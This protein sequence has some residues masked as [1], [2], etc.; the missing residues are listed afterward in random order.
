[1]AMDTLVLAANPGSASRKYSLYDGD[2]LLASLYFEYENGQIVC[3]A[4]SDAGSKRLQLGINDLEQTPEY[5]VK[6]FES[7]GVKVEHGFKCI[8]LRLVAPTSQF[9][10]DCLLDDTVISKLAE[11]EHLVPLHIRASL[12][13]ARGL[14]ACFADTPIVAISDSAFHIT[15]PDYA[16]N[17]AI[18]LEDA[19]QLEIKRFG[20]HGISLASIVRELK[21]LGELPE[22][23]VVCHLGSG[24]SVTAVLNGQSLDTTM[25]YSPLEGLMMATRSGSI[26]IMAALTLQKELQLSPSEL[27]DYLNKASGLL[28]VSGMSSDI[29]ELLEAEANNHYRAGLALRMY[30][31]RIQQAIGQMVASL[32]GVD[33]LVFTAAVGSRSYIIRQ[34]VVE[35]LAY[36]GFSVD[37][38]KNSNVVE[39]DTVQNIG[40]SQQKPIY[41]VTTNEAKEI[42]QR[43]LGVVKN[44]GA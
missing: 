34:R 15:K 2:E 26:D 37:E 21:A 9:L 23:L 33:A 32:E 16:W 3:T 1:M 4:K 22:K 10:K 7:V 38:P 20:Y 43:A 12:E 8:G 6:T 29:R 5:I 11:L 31:Y 13:E 18:P 19:D 36:L 27:E 44:T 35:G 28:G 30:V 14:K 41:V 25:G 17:Y 42:A 40:L 39:P 24:N